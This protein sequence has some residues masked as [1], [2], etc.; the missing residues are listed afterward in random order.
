MPRA[1]VL[2]VLLS[3][4]LC[5]TA[6]RTGAPD[7]G[8]R[9]FPVNSMIAQ[10]FLSE[11][12][13]APAAFAAFDGVFP[14]E[15]FQVSSPELTWADSA[16]S[17]HILL[18]NYSAYDTAY[19]KKMHRLIQRQMP[20]SALTDFWEGTGDDLAAAL[21]NHDIVVIAYPS[22]GDAASLK[23]YGKVL[24]QYVRQ[25]GAVVLTG[26]HEYGVLQQ[27]GL[28][29]LDFGYFCSDPNIHVAE[30]GVPGA[31]SVSA[32]HPI[33]A[34]L[35]AEFKLQNYAYPLD[36]SDPNFVTVADVRGYP[37]MG[38]KTLGSGKIVYLGLEYYYS[39]PEPTRIL[40]NTLRWL[41]PV[42]PILAP[43]ATP[44]NA[45]DLATPTRLVK[46][47]REEIL[48]AGSG[49][50]KNEVFDLKIY[51]NPYASKATLD[52]DLNR[53]SMVSVEMTNETGQIVAVVLPRKNLVP[54]LY[55]LELP[56]LAPG[57]YFVQCQSG[58]KTTVKK[59][60]KT[61]VQ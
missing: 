49:T 20:N 53:A 32:D 24:S 30:N 41:S 38:Y 44:S 10:F 33:V 35:P 46:Q 58:E 34:G 61:A 2:F 17:P 16:G 6:Y 51:P 29:D 57:V 5:L 22:G 23:T 39:E 60:V 55:R 50:V 25:G 7:L 47:R 48:F 54:G 19:A 14:E 12:R 18:L 31:K 43:P 11:F 56:N 26:T 52:I 21:T 37:V 1:V 3:G 8:N 45:T 15:T 42:K 9:P 40:T 4:F 28:F 59:V 36:I 27:Y 13:A